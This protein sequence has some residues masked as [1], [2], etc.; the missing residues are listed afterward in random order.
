[1]QK[2]VYIIIII[3][4]VTHEFLAAYTRGTAGPL[5]GCKRGGWT[6]VTVLTQDDVSEL[7]SEIRGKKIGVDEGQRYVRS[8]VE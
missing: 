1:M 8:H 4:I 2:Q 5:S 6:A 7:R 3:F